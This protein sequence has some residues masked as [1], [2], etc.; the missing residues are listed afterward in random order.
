[1]A[2]KLFERITTRSDLGLSN[3]MLI[4]GLQGLNYKTHKNKFY[5]QPPT[6]TLKLFAPIGTKSDHGLSDLMLICDLQGLI[7]QT[8]K[9][10]V[11]KQPPTIALKLS[12]PIETKYEQGLS[13]QTLICKT[14]NSKT[15]ICSLPVPVAHALVCRRS[16]VLVTKDT[17]DSNCYMVAN[18]KG[19]N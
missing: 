10:Y 19:R 15:L 18:V 2:L 5:K 11:C 16:E 8:H 14:H 13:Y 3:L 7:Y 4:C 12:V 1:M 6:T 17:H 9:K